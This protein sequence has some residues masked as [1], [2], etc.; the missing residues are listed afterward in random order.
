LEPENKNLAIR[1]DP[2]SGVYISG[3]CSYK[4]DSPDDCFKF[5]K[6][7][8]ENRVTAL[9]KMVCSR[10]VYCCIINLIH[11]QNATSSRSHS[12]LILQVEKRLKFKDEDYNSEIAQHRK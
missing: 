12:C 4:I 3:V 6:V 11:Q 5:Y 8:D 10:I 2:D 9:T 1:E 7:G